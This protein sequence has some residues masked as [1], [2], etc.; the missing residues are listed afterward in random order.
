MNFLSDAVPALDSVSSFLRHGY[1]EFSG[2]TNSLVIDAAH[3]Y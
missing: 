2:G 1:Q 3:R